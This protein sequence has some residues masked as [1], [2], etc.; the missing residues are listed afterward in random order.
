MK[1]KSKENKMRK[2]N[3]EKKLS[4]SSSILTIRLSI[5]IKALLAKIS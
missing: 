1:N 4:L 2:E 3:K 5:T